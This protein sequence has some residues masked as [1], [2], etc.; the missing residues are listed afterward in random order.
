MMLRVFLLVC[1]LTLVVAD[2]HVDDHYGCCTREHRLELMHQ[3]KAVWTA[4]F[5]ESKVAMM[6]AIFDELVP[7]SLSSLILAGSELRG[8]FLDLCLEQ[9]LS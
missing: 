1:L 6:R 3:S 8:C 7:H 2:E 5:T 9:P 4:S